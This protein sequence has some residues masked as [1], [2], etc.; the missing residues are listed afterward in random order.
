MSNGVWLKKK[1]ESGLEYLPGLKTSVLQSDTTLSIQMHQ[2]TN[3]EE[4]LSSSGGN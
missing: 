4:Q 3:E 2:E 1:I